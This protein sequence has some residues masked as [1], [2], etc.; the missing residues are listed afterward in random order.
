MVPLRVRVGLVVRARP[1]VTVTVKYVGQALT[2]DF[3]SKR[4]VR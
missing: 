2:V 1:R 3:D 4:M